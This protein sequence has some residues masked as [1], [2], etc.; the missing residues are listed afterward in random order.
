MTPKEIISAYCDAIGIPD[1][2]MMQVGHR[3]PKVYNGLFVGMAR[4]ALTFYLL[5]KFPHLSQTYVCRLVGYSDHTAWSKQWKVT[6]TRIN[7]NDKRFSY[8]WNV[9]N[10]TVK[11]EKGNTVT[12]AA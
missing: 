11:N 8:Y 7:S 1:E 4:N 6:K 10:E 2:V 3:K 5:D 9:L 12:K